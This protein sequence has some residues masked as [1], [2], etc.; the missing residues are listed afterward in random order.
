ML[1]YDWKFTV[2]KPPSSFYQWNR[3]EQLRNQTRIQATESNLYK[4]VG[5]YFLVFSLRKC[6]KW[7]KGRQKLQLKDQW[8]QAKAKAHPWS[9]FLSEGFQRAPDN[10]LHLVTTWGFWTRTDRSI[11]IKVKSCRTKLYRF[12]S[13]T[14][15]GKWFIF[16]IKDLELKIFLTKNQEKVSAE[17]NSYLFVLTAPGL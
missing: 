16:W 1:T 8:N 15:V 4:M 13:L 3:E 14:L 12:F 5:H 9:L 11:K 6:S 7:P 17:C 2:Y 10:V